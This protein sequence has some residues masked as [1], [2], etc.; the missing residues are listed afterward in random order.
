M[1]QQGFP[2]SKLCPQK[3][4]DGFLGINFFYCDYIHG[5]RKVLFFLMIKYVLMNFGKSLGVS[6]YAWS[7]SQVS[8]F[9]G[10]GTC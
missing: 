6:I 8:R 5:K 2:V 1:A 9:L 10:K 4:I 3:R 7:K